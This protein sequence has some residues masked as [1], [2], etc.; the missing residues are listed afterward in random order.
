MMSVQLWP[1][2]P[3][4]HLPEV[5]PRPPPRSEVVARRSQTCHNSQGGEKHENGPEMIRSQRL[6]YHVCAYIHNREPPKYD[7]IT[8]RSLAIV[9]PLHR[10]IKQNRRRAGFILENEATCLELAP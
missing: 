4:V 1:V 2:A 3:A 10:A 6:G 8:A 9:D 5:V 7:S